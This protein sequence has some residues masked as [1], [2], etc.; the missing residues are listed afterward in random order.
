MFRVNRDPTVAGNEQVCKAVGEGDAFGDWQ[1][2]L[3]ARLW[4]RFGQ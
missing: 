2:C 4:R 1:E 3:D